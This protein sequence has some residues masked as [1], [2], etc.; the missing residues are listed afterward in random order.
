MAYRT[1]DGTVTSQGRITI[2]AQLRRQLA[3]VPGRRVT[4]VVDGDCLRLT[5]LE[6]TIESIRGIIPPI[7]DQS[8]DFDDEIEAAM[9]ERA[10]R[11]MA[12]M[13]GR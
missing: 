8:I 11:M 7:P 5:P 9:Q 4:F 13:R 6:H 12:N 1:M 2:P 10:D 3:I